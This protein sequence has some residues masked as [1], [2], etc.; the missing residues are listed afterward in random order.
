VVRVVD[1][2]ITIP[3][4]TMTFDIPQMNLFVGPPGTTRP[5]DPGVVPVDTLAPIAGGKTIAAGEAQHLTV[6]DGSP[7]HDLIASSIQAKT[8]F[9]F[10]LTLAPRLE[11]GAALPAGTLQVVAEPFLGLGLR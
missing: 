8:P 7:A 3:V 9:V 1:V 4:N 2:A 6:A 11:S 10:V 5:T